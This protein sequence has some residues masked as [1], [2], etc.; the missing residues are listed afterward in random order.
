MSKRSFFTKFNEELK[1]KREFDPH[2]TLR[3]LKGGN[4]DNLMRYY[5]WGVETLFTYEKKSLFL[6]VNGY[7]HSGW[8]V[9]T[10]GASDLYEFRLLNKQ[11]NQVGEETTHLYFDQLANS[12]DERVEKQPEYREV[13]EPFKG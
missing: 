4:H 5:S 6:K 1:G 2:T 12:I 10:L 13:N 7:K 8:V 3:L 11:Y 9:I